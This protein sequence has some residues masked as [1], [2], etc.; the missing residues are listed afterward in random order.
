M[1]GEAEQRSDCYRALFGPSERKWA[2]SLFPPFSASQLL[3]CRHRKRAKAWTGLTGPAPTQVCLASATAD[4]GRPWDPTGR[5]GAPQGSRE[6]PVALQRCPESRPSPGPRRGGASSPAAAVPNICSPSRPN[7]QAP[8]PP[9]RVAVVLLSEPA[10]A[11]VSGAAAPSH[12]KQ[13]ISRVN[14]ASVCG[15]PDHFLIRLV[16]RRMA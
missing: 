12:R 7:L 3:S 6:G 2:C 15:G 10:E 4:T 13:F 16:G 14:A 1:P 8:S 9:C 5:G 11:N